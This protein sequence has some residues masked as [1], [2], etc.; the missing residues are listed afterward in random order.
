MEN[1]KEQNLEQ[2]PFKGF[3]LAKKAK[4]ENVIAI[5]DSNG[6]AKDLSAVFM[7]EDVEFIDKGS[8]D[9]LGIIRH[10][11][12][13]LLAAALKKL[14][15]SAKFTIGPSIENGFYYDI[16]FGDIKVGE[17][18]FPKIEAEMNNIIK[19]DSKFVRKNISKSEA[20]EIFKDNKYKLEILGDIEDDAQ[21]SIYEF[22]GYIDLCR[23]PHVPSAR[24]L[25][26]FKLTKI[27]GA[28]WKADQSRD[29]LTRIYGTA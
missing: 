12:A 22:G 29:K 3:D 24:Y 19:E 10:S 1:K 5:R 15:P 8:F 18:D 27:S 23:G 6:E 20:I 7:S 17:N 14:Y 13:H 25:K 2:G 21:I 28:Y 11:S 26:N 4:I 16:D 9:G